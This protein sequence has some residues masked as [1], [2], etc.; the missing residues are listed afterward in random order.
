MVRASGKWRQLAPF[1]ARGPVGTLGGRS[2]VSFASNDYLGLSTHPEVIAAAHRAIDRWGTSSTS[3]R[4][5]VGTRPVHEELE[6]ELAE[7]KHSE[8]AV[9]FPTGFAANLGVLTVMAA[10]PHT[11]VLSDELNHACVSECTSPVEIAAVSIAVIGATSRAPS[12]NGCP[13]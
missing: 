1:D 10:G 3:A 2:V 11:T 7:W 6:Q 13:S 12:S 4:L 5:L 9:V 8:H